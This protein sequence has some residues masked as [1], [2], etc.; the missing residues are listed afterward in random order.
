MHSHI[1]DTDIKARDRLRH[2]VVRDRK[3]TH[4]DTDK[5]T[6]TEVRE[7]I[8]TQRVVRDRKTDTERQTH[9]ER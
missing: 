4:R 2:R 1:G 6:H 5:Q 3:T 9:R 8:K 7:S